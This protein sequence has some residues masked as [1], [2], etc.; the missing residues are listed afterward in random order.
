M[1]ADQLERAAGRSAKDIQAATIRQRQSA[2]QR[3]F[4]GPGLMRNDFKICARSSI[5]LA[6]SLLPILQCTRIQINLR[7]NSARV[8]PIPMRMILMS[9]AMEGLNV[10]TA[11]GLHSACGDCRCFTHRFNKLRGNILCL[12]RDFL[13]AFAFALMFAA[14]DVASFFWSG[15]RSTCSFLPKRKMA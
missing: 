5:R 10:V 15:V 9:K 12:H 1:L 2:R 4:H 3:L 8:R 13:F 6:A 7:A 11:G 14:K